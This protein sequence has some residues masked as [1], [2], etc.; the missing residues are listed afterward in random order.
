[1]DIKNIHIDIVR[2]CFQKNKDKLYYGKYDGRRV[3]SI[4]GILF[5]IFNEDELLFDVGKIAVLPGGMDLTAI[6]RRYEEKAVEATLTNELTVHNN[7]TCRKLING[8]NEA[9]IN[10]AYLK[11]FDPKNNL[12][13]KIINKTNP[14]LVYENGILVGLIFP[15]RIK[16]KGAN[17][18]GK[19]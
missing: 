4:G 9:W 1:M 19:N 17:K 7:W 16:E 6:I 11:R 13:F 3:L 15:I 2:L 10:D 5:Y 18:N 8:T 14:V 12:S